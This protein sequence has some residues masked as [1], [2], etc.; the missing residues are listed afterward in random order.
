[1]AKLSRDAAHEQPQIKDRHDP[2]RAPAPE[3]SDLAKSDPGAQPVLI[4]LLSPPHDGSACTCGRQT[5]RYTRWRL[6]GDA[7]TDWPTTLR[8]CLLM[9]CGSIS[10]GALIALVTRLARA[11]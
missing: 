10:A 1:M 3:L 2:R 9:L 11:G 8:C 4:L 6:I 7:M 5:G